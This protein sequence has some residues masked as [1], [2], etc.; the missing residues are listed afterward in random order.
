MPGAPCAS[1]APRASASGQRA[2]VGIDRPLFRR[3]AFSRLQF[4]CLKREVIGLA[5]AGAG[6]GAPSGSVAALAFESPRRRREEVEEELDS[7]SGDRRI[8]IG[9]GAGEFLSAAAFSR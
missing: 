5:W 3:R 2:D 1:L 7:L 6:A 8:C 9:W 4:S